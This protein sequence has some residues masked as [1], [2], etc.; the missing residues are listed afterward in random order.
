MRTVRNELENSGNL[1]VAVSLKRTA[2]ETKTFICQGKDKGSYLIS[3]A[4]LL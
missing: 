4:Y 1:C 3:R 2:E